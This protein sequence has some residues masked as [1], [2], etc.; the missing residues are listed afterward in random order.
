[1]GEKVLRVE[2]GRSGEMGVSV[3]F[4]MLNPSC[5]RVYVLG[6][7]RVWARE[8]PGCPALEAPCIAGEGLG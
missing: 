2:T 8:G 6:L 5:L 4:E 1:M 3:T 7:C